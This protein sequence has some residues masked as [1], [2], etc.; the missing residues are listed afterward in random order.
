[1]GKWCGGWGCD[2]GA[3]GLHNV[4]VWGVG[5]AVW[6]VGCGGVEVGTGTG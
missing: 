2:M 1:M 4:G 3:R 5:C 6:G